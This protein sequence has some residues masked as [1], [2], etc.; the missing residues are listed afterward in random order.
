[1]TVFALGFLR[2]LLASFPPPALL[3]QDPP[4]SPDPCPDRGAPFPIV[5]APAQLTQHLLVTPCPSGSTFLICLS[6]SQT[7]CGLLSIENIVG[8]Q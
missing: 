6:V 3:P 1:M 2:Y 5:A 4:G 8:A 7:N